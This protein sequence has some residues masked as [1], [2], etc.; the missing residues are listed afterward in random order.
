M[1]F[2]R[3]NHHDG[4]VLATRTDHPSF[5]AFAPHSEPHATNIRI[6]TTMMMA[7]KRPGDIAAFRRCAA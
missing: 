3:S 7:L 6:A 1:P 5:F 4:P 2:T